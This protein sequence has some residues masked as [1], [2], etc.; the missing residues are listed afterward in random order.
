MLVFT[1]IFFTYDYMYLYVYINV[2][3]DTVI[4]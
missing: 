3:K 4:T 1:D 2:I